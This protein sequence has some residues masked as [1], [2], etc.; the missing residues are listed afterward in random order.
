M[1]EWILRNLVFCIAIVAG[2]LYLS[3]SEEKPGKE[4]PK[5]SIPN[6]D[7]NLYLNKSSEL[8]I[9]GAQIATF[10]DMP[11]F[12]WVS[13]DGVKYDYDGILEGRIVYALHKGDH[14]SE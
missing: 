8:P 7:S 13:V 10:Q 2:Y 9:T 14:V 5:H 4:K 12:E 3:S 1:D 6:K 11:I